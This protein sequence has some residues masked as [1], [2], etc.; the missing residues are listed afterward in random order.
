MR[1]TTST[2]RKYGTRSSEEVRGSLIAYTAEFVARAGRLGGVRRVALL[3][4]LATRKAHP[5]DVDLLVGIEDDADLAPLATIARRLQGRAQ[6]LNSTADVFLAN[7]R[8]EYLGR[9]CV[10]RDCRAGARARCAALH[11]G[12][13]PH[14]HDD[15][16]IVRLASELIAGPPAEL[17][18][19]VVRRVSMPADVEQQ[20]LLP[21][22]RLSSN[23]GTALSDE[24]PV[25]DLANTSRVDARG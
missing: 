24:A 25:S 3:G 9:S 18:P 20:L 19:L 5:K 7:P 4:S 6:G 22:E 1:G 23:R 13:R 8:G 10:W 16:Q 14:L 17:W 12:R 21:L 15:L 11:C 2:T